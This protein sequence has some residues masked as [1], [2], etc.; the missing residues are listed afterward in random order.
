ME[1]KCSIHTDDFLDDVLD[2]YW[3]DEIEDQDE[4]IADDQ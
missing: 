3:I 1:R 2:P 4:D